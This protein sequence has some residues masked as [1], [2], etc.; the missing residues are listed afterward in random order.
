[1]QYTQDND[2]NF[3]PSTNDQ[4]GL[5]SSPP[6]GYGWGSRIYPYVK[7]T[8]VYRCPD[9]LSNPNYPYVVSYAF[10]VCLDPTNGGYFNTSSL[11]SLSSP[12]VTV[13]LDEIEYCGSNVSLPLSVGQDW[14]EATDGD[15]TKD[16]FLNWALQ[17]TGP[18]G[19]LPYVN[20]FTMQTGLHT[21]GSNYLLADGH[22]KWLRGSSVSPGGVPWANA[23]AGAT[24]AA[25]CQQGACPWNGPS[26]A[27]SNAA[28]TAALGS[29][30]T[31]QA[32][33]SPL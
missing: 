30:N 2:E 10:N 28:G 24:S 20:Y 9:D 32:T 5:N 15:D 26:G 19:G 17:T 25:N 23:T 29:G 4:V 11:S 14:T 33:F 3:T 1:M 7:S 31:F 6:V 18:L 27:S 12:A 13:L 21:D 8:R 16:D 22:T